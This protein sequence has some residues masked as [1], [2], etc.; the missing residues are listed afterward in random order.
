MMTHSF[1]FNQ[2]E[3]VS[4]CNFKKDILRVVNGEIIESIVIYNNPQDT[5]SDR[6][7]PFHCEVCNWS[8][9]ENFLDYDYDDGFGGQ[10]CHDIYLWTPTRIITVHE[11]DGS[12]SVYGIPRNPENYK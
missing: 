9:V 4:K 7:R 5:Y 1:I 6:K 3:E 11:Y 8:D 10:E 2:G 12:T